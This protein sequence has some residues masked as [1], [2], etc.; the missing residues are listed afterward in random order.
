MPRNL[1]EHSAYTFLNLLNSQVG[2]IDEPRSSRRR[3]VASA[4]P[5]PDRRNAMPKSQREHQ[6]RHKT[7]MSRRSAPGWLLIVPVM[8]F[9][10]VS[11]TFAVLPYDKVI[12]LDGY[13]P[14]LPSGSAPFNLR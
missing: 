14:N 5:A 11:S 4:G 1:R 8:C 3:P 2:D 7:R 12:A 9:A 10:S 6:Q 13:A